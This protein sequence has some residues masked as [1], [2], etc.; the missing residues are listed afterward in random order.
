MQQT[1]SATQSA[2][3]TLEDGTQV[4]QITLKNAHGVELDVIGYGGIITRLL[5][6]DAKGELGDIVLGLDSL[7]EYASSN[8]YFG[9]LIGRYGNRIANGRFTLDGTTYQLDTNDGVNHLHGG[10]QGF[11][12]KVWDMQPFT[13]D[14]SAGVVLTLVSPDDDQGYPGTLTTTVTYEL[15]NDNELD[16]RFSATTDKPTIVNLTQHSYFNL[17]GTGDILDHKLMIPAD[18]ITPVAEGLI[19]TGEMMPVEG[20]PFDFRSAKTIGR[21]IGGDHEQLR[22]GLGYDHNFVLKG[23]DNEELVLAARV[24][25][26]TTGRVLE[27]LTVEPAVQ[28]YSGNF[29]DGSL[30]GKGVNYAH[31]SGFCLEP[32][33]HP[34]SPNQ[35]TFPSTVLRPGETYHTR[36]VYRFSTL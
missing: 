15:N 31:R 13:T 26:P 29:L 36:I 3:G 10:I 21:D 35:S 32:Q 17:A 22:L 19:P 14:S 27:V 6:P 23:Q 5:T 9:A 34:D 24:S 2:Y 20:T 11:D 4:N 33:H 18:A 7:E 30:T 12:K 25:E 8:P 16:M 28:F 1:V